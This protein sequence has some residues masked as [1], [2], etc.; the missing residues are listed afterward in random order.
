MALNRFFILAQSLVNITKIAVQLYWLLLVIHGF[1]DLNSFLQLPDTFFILAMCVVNTCKIDARGNHSTF[2]VNGF[3]YSKCPFFTLN[4]F[5]IFSTSV[6]QE[7]Q[8]TLG[9]YLT[10][11]I[12]NFFTDFEAFLEIVNCFVILL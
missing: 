6:P 8:M 11:L 7:T 1:A 12:A 10:L 9:C 5:S 3:S 4:R 2:V